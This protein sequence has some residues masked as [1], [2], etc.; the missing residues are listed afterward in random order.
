MSLRLTLHHE[1]RLSSLRA[2]RSNTSA[3]LIGTASPYI[4]WRKTFRHPALL[5]LSTPSKT[6]VLGSPR[7]PAR[8]YRHAPAAGS[9][10][11]PRV[12]VPQPICDRM[13]TAGEVATSAHEGATR[14]AGSSE[15]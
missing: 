7:L 5:P 9:C 11:P 13:D 8:R 10:R 15:C 14:P 1:N 6:P 4:N 2:V 12:Q 3:G